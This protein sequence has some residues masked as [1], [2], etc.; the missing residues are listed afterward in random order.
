M[1]H[2]QVI[3]L[4]K[5][6]KSYKNFHRTDLYHRNGHAYLQIERFSCFLHW[7]CR[8]FAAVVGWKLKHVV[9]GLTM[10]SLQMWSVAMFL[11]DQASPRGLG[12]FPWHIEW[13]K[14]LVEE[15]ETFDGCPPTNPI[16]R[17]P[18]GYLLLTEIKTSMRHS[19][20]FH[21]LCGPG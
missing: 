4:R 21:S 7:I 3:N 17:C 20:Y 2:G 13:S 14:W 15:T 1:C 6:T 12:T 9:W 18:V 16:C 19:V 5:P 8:N 10:S 11:I